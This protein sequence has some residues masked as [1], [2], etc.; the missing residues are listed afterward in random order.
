MAKKELK[1]KPIPLLQ[2]VINAPKE[3]KSLKLFQVP[4]EDRINLL[5]IKVISSKI[6]RSNIYFTLQLLTSDIEIKGVYFRF[7]PYHIELFSLGNILYL[8]G[9]V[10]N[11]EQFGLQ[12]INPHQ[13]KELSDEVTAVYK[14]KLI[15]E[16]ISKH[17]TY[18]N[19]KKQGLPSN[20]IDTLLILHHNPTDEMILNLEIFREFSEEIIYALKYTEAF[21]Y[22][23]SVKNSAVDYP[24]LQKLDGDVKSWIKTLPFQLTGDQKKAIENIRVDIKSD[25]AMRR[26]IIGDVG[27]GKTMVILASMVIAHPFKSVLMAPTSILAQQLFNEAEKYLPKKYK[28]VLLTSK[29]SKKIDLEDFDILIGTSAILY[30]ELSEI[31]LIIIDEQ[32]RFGTKDRNRLEKLVQKE[33]KHPHF[34]QL[35]ATPIPRT[36]AM[37]NSTFIKT[38]IIEE[39][40]FKKDIETETIFSRDFP[41]LLEKIETEIEKKNQVLIIYPLVEASE[42]VDYQSLKESESYWKNSFKNVFVTHGK[43][44][45]KED[46]LKEFGEKGSILLATTVVEV[47]IS[48]PK[49][50]VIVIV[51][52]ER[53]GLA[54]LHQ[55]RGRVSRTGLKGYCYLYTK[56]KEE[57]I[58]SRLGKFE[59]TKNGFDIAS[60]DLENRK[61]GDIIKGTKQSGETFVWFNLAKDK[62]IIEDII[63]N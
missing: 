39:T 37:I 24:P 54:T 45:N 61:S 56:S 36:Q 55:L 53:L 5:H 4:Q 2:L 32:H 31:P 12:I 51:G 59:K 18:E 42:K 57:H 47:G 19:L 30:Q 9:K 17:L 50:T 58:T 40:P 22:I 11:S 33:D 3:Y 26:M 16:A 62:S 38:S 43:D 1:N 20:I 21:Q 7:K 15:G 49:L 14:N 35:S 8:R 23:R 29:T 41:R 13:I 46:I 27:S 6:I 28:I 34:I 25:L 10:K 52:A 48:L 44:K 60:M 63:K